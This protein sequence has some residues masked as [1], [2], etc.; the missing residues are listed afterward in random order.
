MSRRAA[1]AAAFALLAAQTSPS[2]AADVDPALPAAVAVGAS[3]APAPVERVDLARTGRS[4]AP[5][6][7]EPVEVSRRTVGVGAHTPVVQRDGTVVVAVAA[8]ELARFSSTGD[9][10]GRVRL[11]TAA[12]IRAPVVLPG[13]GLAVLTSAP[14]VVFVSASGKV[15]ATAPLPRAVV[16]AGP[17][18][19]SNP[20]TGASISPTLD[21]GVAVASGRTFLEMDASGR[22]RSVSLLPER[23]RVVGDLLRGPE[24]WLAVSSTGAVFLVRP[25]AAPRKLGSF[26]APVVHGAALVDGRTLVA[27]VGASRIAAL[28]LRTG[29]VVTRASEGSRATF[30]AQ[31]VVGQS[32]AIWTSTSDGAVVAFDASGEEIAR[33]SVDRPGPIAAPLRGPAPA[34]APRAALLSDRE[35]RVAFARVG[36]KIGVRAPDGRVQTPPERGCSTP[37]A[38]VPTG[39]SKFVLACREGSVVFYAQ[40]TD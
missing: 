26:G 28:D 16:S 23:E 32:G 21:G 15:V 12:A 3:R 20:E 31:L 33:V 4:R 37:G 19:A 27:Q 13:G 30:D 8:P 7:S 17:A 18:S 10:L 5:L 35:G 25:P 24:G 36:G 9:E 38:I 34:P 14:S 40:R 22:L 2:G 11:G 1:L 39:P 6:P 29:S